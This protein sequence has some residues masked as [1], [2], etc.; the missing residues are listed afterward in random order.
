[1]T[2]QRALSASPAN[3]TV[4][5]FIIP[6]FC[7]SRTAE[8]AINS[9]CLPAKTETPPCETSLARSGAFESETDRKNRYRRL[10][11]SSPTEESLDDTQLRRPRIRAISRYRHALS[12]QSE[13]AIAWLLVEASGRS[14]KCQGRRERA[15]TRWHASACCEKIAETSETVN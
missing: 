6:H 2:R 9:P 15:V 10:M 4:C 8:R 7:E 5:N 1:M 14:D 13:T 11:T 12:D 3:W